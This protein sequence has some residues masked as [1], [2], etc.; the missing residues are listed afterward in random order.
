MGRLFGTDGVRGIANR[1]LSIQ[2]AS[3]IG[4]ALAMVLRERSAGRPLVLVGKDTRTSSDMIEAAVTAGLCAG[5]V[6]VAPLGVVPT[7]TVAYLVTRQQAAAGVMISASHNPY[8]F[9]GIKVFGPLGTKLSDE[10]EQEIEDIVLDHG[11]PF[12]YA[13][14]QEVGMLRPIPG[15]KEA[16][17]EHLISTVPQGLGGMKVLVDCANGSASAT[18]GELFRRLGAQ[19]DLINDQPDGR[20][21]NDHC[22]STHVSELCDRVREGGYDL[23][24]A[25]DGDAD[26]CLA[27]DEKGNVID[28]DQMIA[29]FARNLKAAGRL[30]GN[31][32]VVTVMSNYGFFQFAKDNGIDTRATKVGDRYVLETMLREGF[33]IGGEQSG[34]I[35]FSEY[36]TTGDGQLSAVQLMRA[37]KDAGASLSDLAKV[38]TIMPQVLVNVEATRDMKAAINDS[39]ELGQVVRRCEQQLEGRGRVLLR[40]SGTEP[41][42][43][44]M[45]EGND[46]EEIQQIA[47]TI[48]GAITT[49][50]K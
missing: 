37:M 14:A 41:L 47:D 1:D 32:A 10:E 26:R 23:A 48:A 24:V 6:D 33:V 8:H 2:L 40:P 49:Y 34:H 25:F 29:I 50:L 43:R 35:I 9:N 21:V 3:E 28:G 15:G 11:I 17:L 19:A 12:V 44:V 42:I 30:R 16:Y 5:G 27:V 38:I 7:P 46:L 18:A 36:M 20:N 13:S 39:V 31:T 4:V 22:G 45:V